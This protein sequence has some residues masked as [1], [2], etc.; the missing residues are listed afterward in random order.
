MSVSVQNSG[1]P[2]VKEKLER[3]LRQL[4][5]FNR[6]RIKQPPG[7]SIVAGATSRQVV[8]AMP[9]R[10]GAFTNKKNAKAKKNS[11]PKRGL[12]KKLRFL[13][14]VRNKKGIHWGIFQ[15][16]KNLNFSVRIQPTK[17]DSSIWATECPTMANHNWRQ[18]CVRSIPWLCAQ[19]VRQKRYE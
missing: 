3:C 1:Q 14:I 10:K 11:A 9:L 5:D 4:T 6:N 16:K 8:A 19:F 2:S 13:L 15:M 17:K 7:W 12:E 18:K